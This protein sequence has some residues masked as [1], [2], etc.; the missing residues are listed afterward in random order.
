[1]LELQAQHQAEG[2]KEADA[3]L[4]IDRS[5]LSGARHALRVPFHIHVVG[6]GH[7]SLLTKL[8]SEMRLS[9]CGHMIGAR[10]SWRRR[11]RRACLRAA[12]APFARARSIPWADSC[13]SRLLSHASQRTAAAAETDEDAAPGAGGGKRACLAA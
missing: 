10:V 6:C 3:P 2:G 12:G 8:D 5:L 7:V 11:F 9:R 1:M 13:P 4:R